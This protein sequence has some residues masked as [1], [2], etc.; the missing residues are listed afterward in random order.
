MSYGWL[1][2]D[3]ARVAGRIGSVRGLVFTNTEIANQLVTPLIILVGFADI[4]GC[5]P[6][7]YELAV[8]A[9]SNDSGAQRVRTQA[10]IFIALLEMLHASCS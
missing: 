1:P 7:E 3:M 2:V 10:S 5:Y 9:E 4:V 6:D 8:Y